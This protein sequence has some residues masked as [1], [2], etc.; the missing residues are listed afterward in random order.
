VSTWGIYSSNL[1]LRKNTLGASQLNG[2]LGLLLGGVDD[3]T[4]VDAEGVPGGALT[5]SPPNALAELDVGITSE[6]LE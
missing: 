6:D 5:S 2:A 1:Q 4:M 3:L